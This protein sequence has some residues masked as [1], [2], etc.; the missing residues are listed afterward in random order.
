MSGPVDADRV[1]IG[2]RERE[3]AVAALGVHHAA[4]R[5]AADEY[6]ERVGVVIE[7]QVRSEVRQV[8]EDLPLP[9]P[10]FRLPMAA[11]CVRPSLSRSSG[12]SNSSSPTAAA[13]KTPHPG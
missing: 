10:P 13:G 12:P 7:A 11:R 9:C 2:T 4:G 8:F 3:A 5:L 1:R 6:E